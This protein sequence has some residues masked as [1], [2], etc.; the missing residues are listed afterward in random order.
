M[1][2]LQ[3]GKM[4]D[5]IKQKIRGEIIICQYRVHGKKKPLLR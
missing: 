5:M 4:F 1:I 3:S 2:E